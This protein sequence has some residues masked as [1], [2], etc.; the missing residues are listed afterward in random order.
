MSDD[1]IRERKLMMAD[2][3]IDQFV[4]RSDRE[5]F[6]TLMRQFRDSMPG[7]LKAQRRLRTLVSIVATL[8]EREREAAEGNRKAALFIADGA[9]ERCGHKRSDWDEHD[10]AMAARELAA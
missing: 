9:C 8:V 10:R 3:R 6:H 1:P 2:K 5:C 7:G 4:S